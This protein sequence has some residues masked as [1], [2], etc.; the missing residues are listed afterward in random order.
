MYNHLFPKTDNKGIRGAIV[1]SVG[2]VSLVA[3]NPLSSFTPILVYR[4]VVDAH[5]LSPLN[6]NTMNSTA[7][8]AGSVHHLPDVFRDPW[9]FS[10]FR[11]EAIHPLAPQAVV[12]SRNPPILARRRFPFIPLW[13]SLM[14]IYCSPFRFR[15]KGR[16]NLPATGESKP[17]VKVTVKSTANK[18]PAK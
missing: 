4:K 1:G 11:S 12:P 10:V 14:L 8:P 6:Q 18:P 5:D 17:A 16:I 9:I 2:W 7:S 3:V 15:P 13:A